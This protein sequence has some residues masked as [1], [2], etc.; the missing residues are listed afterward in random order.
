MEPA[1]EFLF[2]LGHTVAALSHGRDN[3]AGN[4]TRALACSRYD[5]LG[6]QVLDGSTYPTLRPHGA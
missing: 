1:A 3:R 2:A 4:R 6:A 5:L